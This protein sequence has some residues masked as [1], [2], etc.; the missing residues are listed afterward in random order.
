MRGILVLAL[1]GIVLSVGGCKKEEAAN[2]AASEAPAPAS[3]PASPVASRSAAPQAQAAPAGGPKAAPAAVPTE[4]RAPA[5]PRKL[6]RTVDLRLEV[7][8]SAEVAKRIEALVTSMGG[9]ISASNAE[10]SGDN[11]EYTL[12]VRVPVDRFDQVLNGVRAFAVRID[13]EQQKVEDV[14]NQYID[15]DARRRTLEATEVELRGLL[16]EERQRG[17]KIDEI[18]EIYKQ[19]VDIRSQIEQIQTELNSYDKLAAFS[20]LNI[21]LGP[22]EAAKPISD[23][24]WHPS[25]NLRSSLRTL[26]G[27]LQWL[28]DALIYTLIVLLPVALV[29][30]AAVALVLWIRR[31]VRRLTGAEPPQPP[32]PGGEPPVR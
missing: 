1:V 32:P 8:D 27:F 20:T 12:T 5:I 21:A 19:L 16:A 14:T 24:A 22:T 10:R 29:I 3:A 26:V 17:R 13:H 7:K 25:D 30:T 15:L 31:R 9:Y 28:T 2:D 23:H 4:N 11:L 6:I 18:M